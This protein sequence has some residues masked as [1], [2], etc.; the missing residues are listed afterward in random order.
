MSTIT[1]S[2]SQNTL[3][4]ALLTAFTISYYILA[5]TLTIFTLCSEIA[6]G[7]VILYRFAYGRWPTYGS[8]GR[9]T[10]TPTTTPTSDNVE[11]TTTTTSKAETANEGGKAQNNIT[12]EPRSGDI[13]LPGI[14]TTL[15]IFLMVLIPICI[16]VVRAEARDKANALAEANVPEE[17]RGGKVVFEAGMMGDLGFGA[18][19]LGIVLAVL[20]AMEAG[21]FWLWS[22]FAA[23]AEKQNKKNEGKKR[24]E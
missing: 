16:M 18:L 8:S 7:H 3:T 4:S 17:A 13:T 11:P 20:V 21:F 1:T 24:V 19:V 5:T 6:L 9:Q 23:W 15:H 10:P 12:P 2:Q 22:V 14:L